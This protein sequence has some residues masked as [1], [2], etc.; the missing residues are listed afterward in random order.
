MSFIS[1]C[2]LYPISHITEEFCNDFYYWDQKKM[3][4]IFVSLISEV[5][6]SWLFSLWVVAPWWVYQQI[7][8]ATYLHCNWWMWY[9]YILA[10]NQY[11]LLVMS[12]YNISNINIYWPC[13]KYIFALMSLYTRSNKSRI[14]QQSSMSGTFSRSFR[15]SHPD[16]ELLLVTL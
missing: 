12:V 16:G 6:C 8:L 4:S 7:L 1:D 9:Q 10:L 5:Y 2:S 11:M 14:Y 15:T 3:F 13:C